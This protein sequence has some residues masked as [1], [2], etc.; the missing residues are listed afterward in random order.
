MTKSFSEKICIGCYWLAELFNTQEIICSISQD[1]MEDFTIKK[2]C[3][4]KVFTQEEALLK[5]KNMP[6][7]NN[8]K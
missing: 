2:Q 8:G 7:K 5:I 3:D 6:N 1:E 4:E